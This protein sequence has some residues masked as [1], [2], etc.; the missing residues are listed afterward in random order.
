[1]TRNQHGLAVIAQAFLLAVALTEELPS[2]RLNASDGNLMVGVSIVLDPSCKNGGLGCITDTCTYCKLSET[3]ESAHLRE[4]EKIGWPNILTQTSSS[5]SAETQCTVSV[6]SSDFE[7][8]INIIHDAN[9]SSGGLGCVDENCRYCKMKETNK[10]AHLDFCEDFGYSFK[11]DGDICTA[12]LSEGDVA[13]GVHVVTDPKCVSGGVGC[14]NETC[15]YC[16]LSFSDKSKDYLNCSLFNSSLDTFASSDVLEEECSL[17]FASVAQ[18][19]YAVTD[20]SCDQVNA[21]CVSD[22]CRLCAYGPNASG[23]NLTRCSAF[24][25]FVYERPICGF[26]AIYFDEEVAIIPDA[27]C[28]EESWDCYAPNCRVCQFGSLAAGLLPC[29]DSG[30]TLT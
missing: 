3:A 22:R 20:V 6:S 13:A 10:S 18:A 28:T 8:G 25:D 2:C 15:R 26:E 30:Y 1:M 23:A 27:S 19:L 29:S 9:C 14:F 4:C 7:L 21:S 12:S 16:Q 17:E 24:E 5:S 11:Y